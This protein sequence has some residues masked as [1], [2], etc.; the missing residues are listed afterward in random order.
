M[1]AN[2]IFEANV[3]MKNFHD[4]Q[5]TKPRSSKMSAVLRSNIGTQIVYLLLLTV[6]KEKKLLMFT[7]TGPWYLH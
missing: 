5:R 3:S 6:C 7:E 4:A 1:E 2:Q